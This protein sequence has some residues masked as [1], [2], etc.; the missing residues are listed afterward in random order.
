MRNGRG[1]HSVHLTA[2]PKRALGREQAAS[3]LGAEPKD[4]P[5]PWDP[6][7]HPAMALLRT[8]WQGLGVVG[9]DPGPPP[10]LSRGCG[11]TACVWER[12]EA[13]GG[14]HPWPGA[15]AAPCQGGL[16][17]PGL[18]S[19]PEALH[20]VGGAVGPSTHVAS[21]HPTPATDLPRW[22]TGTLCALSC[23]NPEHTGG[24]GEIWGC[25]PGWG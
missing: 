17:F 18:L 1:E 12:A 22:R 5:V 7:G 21:T 13:G 19:P 10:A 25:T 24:K 15:L 23:R 4:W 16:A 8:R 9:G 2:P 3:V 20:P 14:G 6:G 11:P